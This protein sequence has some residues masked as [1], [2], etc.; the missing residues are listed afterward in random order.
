VRALLLA[1]LLVGCGRE[2]YVPP[3][4]PVQ[5]RAS[6]DGSAVRPGRPFEVVVEVDKLR[7][8][9]YELPDL[10][11]KIER[12]VVV[13]Q[14]RTQ[15][16]AGDRVLIRDTYT[17]KAPVSGT[18]IIPAVD[19]P[20]RSGD[21]VGTAGTGQIVVEAST[22]GAPTT[23]E[24]RD[25]KP[26]AKPDPDPWP[27]IV[28]A[29]GLALLAAI[30]VALAVWLRRRT[31]DV[32]PPLPPDERAR[33]ALLALKAGDTA[34][35]AAFAYRLSAVLRRYLEERFGFAAWRMTT[36]EVLR[37]MP[38]ELNAQRSVEASV[39]EVLEASDLVK[40]AGQPVGA[41]TLLGWADRALA[42]VEATRPRDEEAA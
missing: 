4:V 27:W 22:D 15:E 42:V 36:H 6:L 10:G 1:L 35:E 24:L 26:L 28:A 31:P 11:P 40:F 19:A 30:G 16:T 2:A 29:A 13:D 32:A 8:A 20:W 9:T 23:E 12:L 7:D 33:Q 17:L 5:V 38:P 21:Q 37:A 41:A 3:D 14:K 39:R 25:L 34:D 18:Y